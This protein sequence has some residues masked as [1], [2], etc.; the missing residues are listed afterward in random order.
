M[1]NKNHLAGGFY[2]KTL[3]HYY[4][5]RF[6]ADFDFLL[7]RFG[8]RFTDFFV[9]F[10]ATFFFAAVR[11]FAIN[12]DRENKIFLLKKYSTNTFIIIAPYVREM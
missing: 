12:V 2:F 4:R 5:L 11:F 6:A 1:S 7:E 10:F 9:D 8:D 3:H